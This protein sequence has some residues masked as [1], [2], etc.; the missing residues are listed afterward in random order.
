MECPVAA[1][2]V[3][4]GKAPGT[5][6]EYALVILDCEGRVLLQK[7]VSFTKLLRLL[8]EKRPKIL[9]VDNIM[10]LGR[11]KRELLKVLN[12]F[13]PETSVVQ[14]TRV[15]GM[16]IDIKDLAKKFDIKVS[17]KL[18]PLET[19]YILG[20]LAL[21]GV[22]TK[23]KAYEEKTKI[24]VT[25]GRTPRAGG[26]SM[27]R[28][29]RATKNAVMET[30]RE[31]KKILDEE[32]FDYDLVTRKSDGSIESAVF[33]VY[34][35][36]K[37]LEGKIKPI[38]TSSVKVK[39]R[40]VI[41][42]HITFE[43]EDKTEGKYLIVG[44]DP[45]INTGLAIIDL[46][47]NV[48]ITTTLQN[49]DRGD[50]VSLIRKFGTPI[51]V[52]V[53]TNPPPH[54]AK[55][56]ASVLKAQLYIPRSS[57][58][59]SEKERI[60][61]MLKEQGVQIKDSHQR[62]A[63]AAAYKAWIE[64]HEKLKK[65]DA[66]LD[67]IGIEINRDKIKVEVLNGKSLAEAVEEELSK[68]IEEEK[69][70][71]VERV[72]MRSKPTSSFKRDLRLAQLEAENVWL[73]LKL[74]ELEEEL[75]KKELE[76]NLLKKDIDKAIEAKINTLKETLR[77]MSLEVEN[78]RKELQIKEEKLKISEEEIINVN[79]GER[80][81]GIYIKTLT[82]TTQYPEAV[83]EKS[84]RIIYAEDVKDINDDFINAIKSNNVVLI[85]GNI[86]KKAEKRLTEIGIPILKR[87]DVR[88]LTKI[89]TVGND[90]FDEWEKLR[91][92]LVKGEVNVEDIEKML[93]EYRLARWK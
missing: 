7:V 26:S 64:V 48:L 53:D 45:G 77:S 44:F 15:N 31:I 34:T 62:D 85:V 24:V 93:L 46:E 47:G 11:D 25:K 19:A 49:V 16:F 50:I 63:I 80:V 55:K 52:A 60:E 92:E 20:V 87:N 67:K 9:A 2:D 28:F 12:L 18:D 68:A 57:L 70:E 75:K 78:L 69:V 39:I 10:E 74:N 42:R 90:V 41:T 17:G 54:S 89:V 91:E 36:R 72:P 23:L 21:K 32:G 3:I 83:S 71:K 88:K 56:L 59:V 13:P 58:S 65:V 33:T 5:K 37:N 35:S 1:I 40:P 30:V 79:K 51:I 27:N 66:Y 8:W 86:T 76:I 29:K 14:V 73:K 82:F 38:S 84:L 43:D 61:G 81:P 6:G 22:G 4:P